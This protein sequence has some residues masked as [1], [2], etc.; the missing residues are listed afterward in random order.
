MN[1]A[2]GVKAHSGWA[3]FV[4]VGVRDGDFTVVDR[5]RVELVEEE[6]AKQPYHAAEGLGLEAAKDVVRRGVEGARRIADREMR[7]AVKREQERGN[8]VEACAVL[9]GNPMP[10]WGIEEILGVHFRLHKAEGVLFREALVRAAG[11]SGLRPVEIPEM[12]LT[13]RAKTDLGASPEELS[14]KVTALGRAVGPPWGKDQKDA[15]LAAM[16]ALRGRPSKPDRQ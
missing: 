16:V 14:G 11:A 9:V 12:Q 8:N 4:V 15:A 7:K 13:R 10:D 6:W 1:V 5:R 2:L 3:V